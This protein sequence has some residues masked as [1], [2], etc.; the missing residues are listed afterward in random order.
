MTQEGSLTPTPPA[1]APAAAQPDEQD[2]PGPGCCP[3]TPGNELGKQIPK[4]ASETNPLSELSSDPGTS[5]KETRGP[6]ADPATGPRGARTDTGDTAGALGPHL[7]QGLGAGGPE[8]GQDRPAEG[9]GGAEAGRRASLGAQAGSLVLGKC[10]RCPVPTASGFGGSA[11]GGLPA[12]SRER[13]CRSGGARRAGGAAAKQRGPWV[14]R[15]HLS[16]QPS[17]HRCRHPARGRAGR[18]QPLA[19]SEPLSSGVGRVR[20]CPASWPRALVPLPPRAPWSP[21]HVDIPA[22][23]APP[24]WLGPNLGVGLPYFL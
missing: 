6:A 13:R 2:L 18:C 20:C 12:A 23:A 22:A 15:G 8:A 24:E 9:L 3:Q 17:R 1:E 21:C 4:G 19:P 11:P 14:L 10:G 5:A 16:K 7:D